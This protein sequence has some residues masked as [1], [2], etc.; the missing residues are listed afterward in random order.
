MFLAEEVH[1]SCLIQARA[2]LDEGGAGVHPANRHA[3][4]LSGESVTGAPVCRER[5]SEI[6]RAFEGETSLQFVSGLRNPER[7]LLEERLFFGRERGQAGVILEGSELR[8]ETQEGEHERGGETRHGYRP[9]V[10]C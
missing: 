9:F 4:L 6:V 7:S 3:G 5:T 10:A 8:V 2:G 1:H